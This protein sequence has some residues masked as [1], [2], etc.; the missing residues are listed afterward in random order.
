M[1]VWD[2]ALLAGGAFVAVT[3][4]VG[5]MR[6]RRDEIVAELT[7]KA[8]QELQRKRLDARQSKRKSQDRRAA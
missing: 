6:R 1:D 8:S 2:W 5:L 3:T 7:A 4:L